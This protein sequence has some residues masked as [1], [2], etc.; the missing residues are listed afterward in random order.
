M[1]ILYRRTSSARK[2][3]LWTTYLEQSHSRNPDCGL[4]ALRKTISGSMKG[5]ICPP[6]SVAFEERYMRWKRK[7][8]LGTHRFLVLYTCV[9]WLGLDY[10]PFL[11]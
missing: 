8:T 6:P 5:W 7:P 11:K 1:A 3:E 10:A 2:T 9:Q 4:E